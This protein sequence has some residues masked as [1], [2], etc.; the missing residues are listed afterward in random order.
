MPVVYEAALG[1]V[2]GAISSTLGPL[3]TR[4]IDLIPD[5]AEKA[6]QAALIQTQ[7][8]AADAAMATQQNATNAIEAGNGNL[9]VSGWRPFIGWMCG[10][11]LSWQL[12]VAPLI[13]YIC[14]MFKY[15]PNFPQL[16]SAWISAIM[17]PLLGLGGLKTLE[18][19]NGVSNEGP[20]QT[21]LIPVTP[22]KSLLE[23]PSQSPGPTPLY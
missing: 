4:L 5:P 21:K 14:A 17:L 15:Y 10:V 8:M 6:R 1:A 9:F 3:F 7:L 12:L 13:S 16:D 11:S 19:I 18:R 2:E 23:L 22:S 20:A